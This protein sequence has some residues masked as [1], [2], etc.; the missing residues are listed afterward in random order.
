MFYQHRLRETVALNVC[1]LKRPPNF[2]LFEILFP[3]LSAEVNTTFADKVMKSISKN[4]PECHS[5]LFLFLLLLNLKIVHWMATL[6][7]MRQM[8]VHF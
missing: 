6:E 8:Y 5:G 3:Q 2:F 7:A 4:N 1:I